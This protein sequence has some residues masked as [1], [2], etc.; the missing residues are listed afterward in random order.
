MC[1]RDSSIGDPAGIERTRPIAA[2]RVTGVCGTRHN[3]L[4]GPLSG[5]SAVMCHCAFHVLSGPDAREQLWPLRDHWADNSRGRSA[6]TP[7]LVCHFVLDAPLRVTVMGGIRYGGRAT[8]PPILSGV[9]A[10]PGRPG[11][12]RGRVR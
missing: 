3:D 4:D 8:R 6:P 11:C 12:G 9:L 2:L 5:V 1:I 10:W 7:S